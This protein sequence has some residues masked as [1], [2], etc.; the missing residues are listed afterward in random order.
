MPLAK[1]IAARLPDGPQG[2][3]RAEVLAAAV[4]AVARRTTERWLDDPQ[5]QPLVEAIRAN[6]D[7]LTPALHAASGRP[8]G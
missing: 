5:G 3:A 4:S 2:Q 1:A 7:V 6:I 8:S